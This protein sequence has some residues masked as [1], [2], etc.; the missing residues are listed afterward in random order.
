MN[1]YKISCYSKCGSY[2]APY[3]QSVTIVAESA[4]QAVE[5]LKDWLKEQDRSFINK[6]ESAWS[7]S[8]LVNEPCG[9]IDW[10]EESDY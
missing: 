6:D 9:V 3:L 7:V 8:L 10:H 4:E 2:F 5:E 1:V